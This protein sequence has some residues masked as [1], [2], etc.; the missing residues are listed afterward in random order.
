MGLTLKALSEI[1]HAQLRGDPDRVVDRVA[2][3]QHATEGALSFLANPHYRSFLKATKASAV[4]L[5]AEDAPDCPV[6]CLVS[7]NPYLSHA[8]AMNALYPVAGAMPGVH[9]TAHLDPTAQVA[10][11]VEIGANCYL[12]SGVVVEAGA[13]VGPGCVLL[14]NVVIG[15]DSRLV[16]AVTL[17]PETRLGKRCLI[18]PGAVIGAD[19]FGLANDDGVW[20]KVPQV[21]CVVLGDDV[22]VGSCSSIDRGAIA[23]TV[24]GDGVKIDSQVHVAHNVQIGEHTAIAGCAAIAGSSR[25]GAYCT[26]AG[27]AGITGHVELTDHVHVSGVTSV[28]RSINKPGMYTGTVPAMDHA[29][30]LKNFSRLRQLDDMAR[31]LKALERELQ[32]LR[33]RDGAHG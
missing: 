21:G 7:D 1:A 4:I 25:V 23:N 22:E 19:G 20:V 29:T 33:Q 10:S 9:P 18:H 26:I 12:G 6:D 14:D 32:K 24:I 2:T 8:R 13:V 16:A 3:L 15:T 5:S 31:R 28:T 27:G 30:W 17:C 11:D